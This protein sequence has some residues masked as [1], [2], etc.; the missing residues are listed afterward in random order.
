MNGNSGFRYLEAVDCGH[1]VGIVDQVIESAGSGTY[2]V[3]MTFYGPY[4]WKFGILVS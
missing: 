1:K 3:R 2:R 4:D